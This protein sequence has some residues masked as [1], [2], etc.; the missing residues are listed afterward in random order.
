LVVLV[1]LG[2]CAAVVLAT[3][4]GSTSV[5]GR[6]LLK[7][8][9]LKID[10]R[11][12]CCNVVFTPVGGGPLAVGA[13]QTDGTYRL[14]IGGSFELSPG[15]YLVSVQALKKVHESSKQESLPI[16]ELR[17]PQML[18]DA[19]ESELECV[20]KSGANVYDVQIDAL[21]PQG[22]SASESAERSPAHWSEANGT[23]ASGH[24]DAS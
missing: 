19:F 12:E 17:S 15:R 6:V 16:W 20:V 21:T 1:F 23:N 7:G 4:K 18:G 2:A 24:T 3:P 11:N 22:F 13:V 14:A 5:T 8:R 10:D 9:P